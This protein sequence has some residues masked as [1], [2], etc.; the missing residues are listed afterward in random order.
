VSEEHEAKLQMIIPAT[1]PSV[2]Q[3]S[4]ALYPSVLKRK[5]PPSRKAIYRELFISLAP[6][7]KRTHSLKSTDQD[8]GQLHVQIT[9]FEGFLPPC[10]ETELGDQTCGSAEDIR[11]AIGTALFEPVAQVIV[12]FIDGFAIFQS[13]SIGRIGDHTA[14]SLGWKV[15]KARSDKLYALSGGQSVQRGSGYLK[16]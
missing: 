9:V 2:P 13:H 1:H 12:D 3:K 11:F 14:S 8:L 5:N 10:P 6:P 15:L 7:L 16:R 4:L